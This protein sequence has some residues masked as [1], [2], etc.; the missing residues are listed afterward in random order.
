M[1]QNILSSDFSCGE[2]ACSLAYL[3]AKPVHSLSTDA[4]MPTGRGDT[5]SMTDRPLLMTALVS[6][7]CL[8]A[9]PE[10]ER[11]AAFMAPAK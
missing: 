6:S 3:T 5:L 2:I 4:P 7:A 11:V 10:I 8:A 9:S 1:A